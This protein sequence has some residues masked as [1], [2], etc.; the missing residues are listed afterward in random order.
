MQ[1]LIIAI[2][3]YSSTGKS[4]LA[5]SL[6]ESLKYTHIDSGAMYRAVTLYALENGM[7]HGEKVNEFEFIPQ[8]DF[9]TIHFEINPQTGKNEI[10]LDNENVEDKIRTME[11]SSKV[12]VIAKIP[13]V[14]FF[15]VELQRE[16]GKDKRVVMDGRD[17]GTT[18]FPNA[19]LKIFLCASAEERAKRRYEELLKTGASITLEEVIANVEERDRIDTTREVSPLKKA[20]DAIEVDNGNLTPEQTLEKVLDILHQKFS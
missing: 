13:E 11:V 3:G 6:A 15:L 20:E 1:D 7:I 16:L 5:K 9:I 18:V 8:L 2:D 12:S 4:T 14:R 10:Y 19:D 17:I